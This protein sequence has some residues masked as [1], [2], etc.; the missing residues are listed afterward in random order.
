MAGRTSQP[1]Q[2]RASR[3]AAA[4]MSA[5]EESIAAHS[6]IKAF[7]LQGTMLAGYGRQ[8]VKLYR[9]TVHASLMSGLQATS[10]SGSGSI[11]LIVAIT[12]GATLA[13][14]GE[15]SVGGLVAVIDLLWF[16]VASLQA[17]AGVV[18][19]LQRAAGGMVRIQEM[20]DAHQEI[21]DKVGRTAA[22]ALF[23][24]HSVGPRDIWLWP[25]GAGPGWATA[26]IRAGESVAIVGPSG[27]G[28]ST[29]LGLLLRLQRSD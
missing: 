29:L 28:K 4:V 15:L 20:L 10:I 19:P 14:W 25:R 8:L 6:V 7:D 12:G 22:A 17:L 11:L 18:P 5:T 24:R 3:D 1:R 27:S 16:I 21:V 9:S 23:R 2:L 26:T 13:V